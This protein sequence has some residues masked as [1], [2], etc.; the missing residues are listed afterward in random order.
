[1]KNT[2]F[3]P[4]VLAG[5]SLLPPE[6]SKQTRVWGDDGLVLV[7]YHVL[8]LS[9]VADLLDECSKALALAATGDLPEERARLLGADAREAA[10]SCRRAGGRTE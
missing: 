10:A 6:P 3:L 8:K 2:A 5:P 4:P 1:M 9:R 7:G